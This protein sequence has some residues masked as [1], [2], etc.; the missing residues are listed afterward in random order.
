MKT[1]QTVEPEQKVNLE[2]PKKVVPDEKINTSEHKNRGNA[3]SGISTILKRVWGYA[4]QNPGGTSGWAIA[5]IMFLVL[6][7]PKVIRVEVKLTGEDISILVQPGKSEESLELENSVRKVEKDPKASVIDKAIAEAYRLKQAGKIDDSIEKWR[8]IAN[9]AEGFDNDLAA[10][11]WFA[12]GSLLAIR[13][14]FEE[15]RKFL[16]YL[17]TDNHFF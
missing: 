6:I 2:Q 10:G 5:V 17:L 13:R 8:S 12:V 7:T 1:E 14:K 9:T 16:L 11:A 4:L 15:K 3:V